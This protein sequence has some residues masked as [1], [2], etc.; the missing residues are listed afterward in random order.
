MTT[1]TLR[2]N[3]WVKLGSYKPTKQERDILQDPAATPAAK[4]TVAEE[5]DAKTM[6]P[7]TPE[8]AAVLN[9]IYTLHA[10]ENG[11]LLGAH[12]ALPEKLGTLNWRVGAQHVQVRL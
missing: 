5:I 11:V 9:E 8:E 3:V 6:I 7:A 1:F 2:N 4:R 10:P 12:I